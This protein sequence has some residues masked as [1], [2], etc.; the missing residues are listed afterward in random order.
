MRQEMKPK[1]RNYFFIVTA[2]VVLLLFVVAGSVGL[3][4]ALQ[5]KAE[6]KRPQKL[7]SAETPEWITKDIIDIHDAARTG[8]KLSAIHNIVIHYVGNPDT[9]A[10]QNRDYFNNPGTEVSA[11]FVVG[12]SGEILQCLPLDEKSAAS[13]HRNFDTISIEI[14]HPDETGKFNDKTY[15][16]LVRLLAFL[17]EN[18]G[19]TSDDIIRHYDVTKKACP[20][21]YVEHPE[22]FEALKKDVSAKIKEDKAK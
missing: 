14:C 21:Y 20:L 2:V 6:R 1:K 15:R 18:S 4:N 13:N 10:K 5:K 3:R 7:Q 19:L 22:S 11:H 16:S 8:T 9:T 17:C 12:L